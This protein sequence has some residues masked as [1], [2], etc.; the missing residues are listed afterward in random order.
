M[1]KERGIG[2]AII[3]TLVTCGIYGL[4]WMYVLTEE[5]A[6]LSKD[7]AFNG[8]IAVI[9]SLVTCG[10]YSI[11]W[12]Y[13]LGE[14]IAKAQANKGDAVK[15]NGVLYLVLSFFG[16][17]IISLAIAQSDVNKLVQ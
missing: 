8:G 1:V 6:V 5:V 9:L 10:L 15:D 4:Y 17:G 11:Y 14:K 7:K 12:N 13:Q 3:L 16:L 2:L